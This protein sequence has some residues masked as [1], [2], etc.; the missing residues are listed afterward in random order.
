MGGCTHVFLKVLADVGVGHFGLYACGFE[1]FRVPDT[2]KLEE[3]GRL[4]TPCAEDDFAVDI[5]CMLLAFMFKSYASCPPLIA[6]IPL[7][8]HN[9]LRRCFGEQHQ[10]LSM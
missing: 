3:L 7:F 6:L 2:R 10:I 5:D 8:Q 4:D 1:D 9:L